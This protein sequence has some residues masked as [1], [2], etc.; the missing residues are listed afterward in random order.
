MKYHVF[1]K[2]KRLKN[3]KIVHRWYYYYLDENDKQIQRACQGCKTRQEAEDYIRTLWITDGARETPLLIKDI[4]AEMFIPGGVHISR[5][6]QLGRLL[7]LESLANARHFIKLIIARWGDRP[8]A[9]VNPTEVTEYLFGVERSGSWK[10]RYQSIFG[11]LY[12][13]AQW[14]G[15]AIQKPR[16]QN[17]AKRPRK[18]DVLTTVEL[19]RLFRLENFNSDTFY[20]MF[21]LCLSGGLRLGEAR[22]VRPKQI[23]FER[24]ALIVDGFCKQDGTRTAYNKTGSPE[25]PR[26]RVVM[27]SEVTLGK[28]AEYLAARPVAEDDFLFT[29]NGHA[30]KQIRAEDA[31][32]RAV[33]A[34]GIDA[35]GR[36]IVCH[37]LRYTYV[38]RMRRELPAEIVRKMAGHTSLEMT[39]YY[40]NRLALDESIA[41]L[42]GAD[43]A[44]DN[45]FA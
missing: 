25:N 27:I 40:T 12:T 16:F 36:K 10:N 26:F 31:F 28:V 43:A 5:L 29:E 39:D 37:S 32:K 35:A 6:E 38:T 41:G 22:A 30:I 18:A 2:P 4:A 19:Q 44:A 14:R 33:A 3:G 8:L 11:E 13:E 1:K 21:L 20:T 45:L 34:A 42:I 7:A 9:F 23:L 17:F 15:L 24:K